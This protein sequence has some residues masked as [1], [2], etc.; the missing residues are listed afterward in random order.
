MTVPHPPYSS[1]LALSDFWLFG[2]IK[3]SLAARVFNDADELLEAVIEFL[4]KIQPSELQL[5]FHHWIV[6]VEWIGA[7]NGDY[8]H[9]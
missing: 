7:N 1:D 5:V 6:R 9:K 8:Y 2:H 4:N 3:T